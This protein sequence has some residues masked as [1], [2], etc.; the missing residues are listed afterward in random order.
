MEFAVGSQVG[1]IAAPS[2]LNR[3]SA[4]P[5]TIAAKTDFD[6]YKLNNGRII[7]AGLLAPWTAAGQPTRFLPLVAGRFKIGDR[8]RFAE[9][10][11]VYTVVYGPCNVYSMIMYELNGVPAVVE[12][13]LVPVYN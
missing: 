13:C 7:Q 10:G 12:Q 1:I 4:G 8:V 3:L 11:P 5:F 9:G 2:L 6:M